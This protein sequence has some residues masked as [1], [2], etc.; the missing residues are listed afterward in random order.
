MN[1]K[2]RFIDIHV[3]QP[4]PYANLNRDDTNSVKSML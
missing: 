1:L 4:V 3:V 2:P